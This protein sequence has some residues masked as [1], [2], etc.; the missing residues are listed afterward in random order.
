MTMV[1]P[2]GARA[3]A[4]A[5]LA[6]VFAGCSGTAV[7]TV[8]GAAALSG[9]RADTTCTAFTLQPGNNGDY[10]VPIGDSCVITI[11]LSHSC[12]PSSPGQTFTFNAPD[13]TGLG[14]WSVSGNTGTFTRKKAGNVII[15]AEQQ[16]SIWKN[17][18]GA[19]FP[20]GRFE[21]GYVTLTT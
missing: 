5:I 20:D 6:L 3:L 12:N 4:V 19:C 17:P 18:N 10:K 13:P 21:Y 1:S 11:P 15:S 7:P 9:V 14:T 16:D 2:L 8:Q